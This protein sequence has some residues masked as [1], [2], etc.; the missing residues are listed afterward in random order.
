VD[1]AFEWWLWQHLPA[2]FA[3]LVIR[4]DADAAV[5]QRVTRVL[6]KAIAVNL[7]RLAEVAGSR[8]AEL[9]IPADELARYLEQFVYRFGEPEEQAIGQFERLVDEL[10]PRTA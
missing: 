7:G 10:G 9:G 2:V 1:L 5:K 8:S 3:V 4:K 6:S